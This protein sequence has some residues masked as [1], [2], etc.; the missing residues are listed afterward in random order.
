MR[1]A[2]IAVLTTAVLAVTGRPAWATTIFTL[3]NN[4]QPGE[5]NI[6]L[7]DGT[8]GTTV[9][10][11]TNQSN[12]SVE[13]D[14]TQSLT[15]PILGQ[16]RIEATDGIGQ[17]GLTNVTI[18]VPNGSYGD[19]IFN[20]YL[21]A[22]GAGDGTLTVSVLDDFGSIATFSYSIGNGSN[23]LTITT[24]GGQRIVS[25][26]MSY[27]LAGGF[28]DL[29]QIRISDVDA[30]AVPEPASLT[31]LGLGLAGMGARRWRQRTP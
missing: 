6:L 2:A 19:L 1:I 17:I 27:D 24:A 14:S 15:E 11:T 30:P 22:I 25:T 9:F 5:E 21:G 20:P 12:A 4:P 23:F 7:N 3:G 31:L 13:F 18:S 29:R 28:T 16:A 26:N 8:V 10:G